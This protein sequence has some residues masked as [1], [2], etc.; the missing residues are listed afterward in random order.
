VILYTV[1]KNLA[2]IKHMKINPIFEACNAPQCLFPRSKTN[3]TLATLI[4]NAILAGEGKLKNPLKNGELTILNI[5]DAIRSQE[6]VKIRN[7]HPDQYTRH[8]KAIS[9]GPSYLEQQI[10]RAIDKAVKQGII[11]QAYVSYTRSQIGLDKLA[12]KKPKQAQQIKEEAEHQIQDLP[13]VRVCVSLPQVRQSKHFSCGAAVIQMVAAYYGNNIREDDLIK[14]LKIGNSSGVK[15]SKIEDIAKEIGLQTD[16]SNKSYD[17]IIKT[18]DQKIPMVVAIL[19][20]GKDYHHFVL[21]VGYYDGGVVFRDPSKFVY[22][23]LPEDEFKR[24]CFGTDGTYL[25]LSI[26]S[27]QEPEYSPTEVEKS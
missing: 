10:S 17:E 5:F 6:C 18:V 26:T 22:G 7:Y 4:K 2:N 27:N 13:H 8:L 21:V 23:Y 9:L 1:D 3:L 24:R 25:T 16:R 19:K 12:K 14:K 11:P 15:L 20:E